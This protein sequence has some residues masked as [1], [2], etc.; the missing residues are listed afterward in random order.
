MDTH[1]KNNICTTAGGKVID[2]NVIYEQLDTVKLA[3]HKLSKLYKPIRNKNGRKSVVSYP[4]LKMSTKCNALI[5][6]CCAEV[7]DQFSE[8]E[9][10]NIKKAVIV[11]LR[12][13][14]MFLRKVALGRNNQDVLLCLGMDYGQR[15]LMI[16][17]QLHD[18]A[19]EVPNIFDK[20]STAGVNRTLVLGS[21]E[22]LAETRMN[23]ELLFTKLRLEDA[24]FFF[25]KTVALC[26]MK[27][28]HLLCGVRLGSK[29]GCYKVSDC[30]RAHPF[31]GEKCGHNVKG[32]PTY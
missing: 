32:T 27:A 29:N 10:V 8:G 19:L 7:L 4:T 31:T 17:A 14:T 21:G 24:I 26:D 25:K 5:S 30:Y 3:H 2:E 15:K 6:E 9:V 23:C 11:Y 16:C 20:F 1:V 13:S 28:K 18:E 12:N 22:F